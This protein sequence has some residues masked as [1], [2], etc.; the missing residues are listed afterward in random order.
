MLITFT[1]GSLGVFV[2][3]F[4]I[5][6]SIFMPQNRRWPLTHLTPLK[7]ALVWIPT[8]TAFGSILVLG[9]LDW[10]HFDWPLWIRLGIGLPLTLIGRTLVWRGVKTLGLN[11]TSGA[12]DTLKTGGIYAYSRNPQYTA[13]I[14]MVCG[15]GIVF[16]SLWALPLIFGTIIVLILTPF[17]EEP[18]LREHYGDAYVEYCEKTPRFLPSFFSI[19]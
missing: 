14:I 15:W 17:A 12:P 9:V 13:D 11:A 7:S 18:W 16:A 2:L 4:A 10:N 5:L 8:F 1:L 6:W 3:G 19:F